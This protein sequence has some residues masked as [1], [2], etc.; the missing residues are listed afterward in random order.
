MQ[1]KTQQVDDVTV[2]MIEGKLLSEQ[3]TSG[4][5]NQILQGL[6][7]N[8]RKYIFDLKG[9]EFVNSACLNFLVSSKGIVSSK[10]G[11]MVLCNLPD[12]L[13]KLLVVTKL[14]TFFSTA[15]KTGDA[16]E[17]LRAV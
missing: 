14:E 4:I 7:H 3:E 11:H 10:G 2:L 8:Q 5:K 6:E 13:K 15:A 9:I 12:Q 17:M 1:F 16:L